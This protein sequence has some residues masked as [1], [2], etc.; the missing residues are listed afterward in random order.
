MNIPEAVKVLGEQVKNRTLIPFIGSGVSS[1]SGLPTA[2]EFLRKFRFKKL[3]FPAAAA[4]IS[5]EKDF[6]G[7]FEKIFGSEKS[8]PN[9]LHKLLAYLEAKY[10]ITTN[11]DQLLENTFKNIY[12]NNYTEKFKTICSDGHL[13]K[14][15]LFNSV[16]IKLHGDIIDQELLVFTKMDYFK[17]IKN[18]TLV[19]GLVRYLF[20]TNTILFIG[21]SLQDDNIFDILQKEAEIRE[22]N[23]HRDKYI[24][25]DKQ[26]S[27]IDRYLQYLNVEPIYLDCDKNNYTNKLS[28]FL[29]EL[30]E[31]RDYYSTLT[32]KLAN[33]DNISIEDTTNN[34]IIYKEYDTQK[35]EK[36]LNDIFAVLVDK[37]KINN[38][39]GYINIIPIILWLYVNFYDKRERWDDLLFLEED[40]I[41]PILSSLKN[42]IPEYIYRSVKCSYEGNMANAMLRSLDFEKAKERF[43]ISNELKTTPTTP[44]SL[45]IIKANIVTVGA[46]IDYTNSAMKGLCI[47]DKAADKLKEADEIYKEFEDCP[48]LGRF[49]GISALIETLSESPNYDKVLYHSNLSHTGS[50]RTKY[51]KIAGKY[52]DAYCHYWIATTDS[53]KTNYF[54]KSDELL[55]D[56][57]CELKETQ[58]TAKLKIYGLLVKV[59]QRLN[60]Q[61]DEKKYVRLFSE[62]IKELKKNNNLYYQRFE[63]ISLD[64]WLK[65]PLN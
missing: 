62:T 42:R 57:E 55:R 48:H 19:D 49:H 53:L 39:D 25:L 4:I 20:A 26:T 28:T 52:C 50:N 17:R 61:D 37:L 8:Q 14:A 60:S 64:N 23:T 3:S 11:Y 58:L 65:L 16:L 13:S 34:V 51:G 12:G 9:E 43:E 41:S 27:E 7:K 18:P 10:Y 33:S 30:W 21:Y 35:A 24:I 29:Y 54:S 45:K 59:L 6:K 47:T 31:Y 5:Q 63:S 46:I 22:K 1:Q 2:Q 36:G 40:T 32:K 15:D 38:L 56:C 44:E